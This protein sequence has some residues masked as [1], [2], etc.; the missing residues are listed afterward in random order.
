MV[1]LG[2]LFP[3]HFFFRSGLALTLVRPEALSCLQPC[4]SHLLYPANP[5]QPS[6][7]LKGLRRQHSE[8]PQ[9]PAH[10]ACSPVQFL[11]ALPGPPDSAS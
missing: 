7:Q 1:L 10:R 6:T 2:Q 5:A 11:P 8:K 3:L 9:D 4:C